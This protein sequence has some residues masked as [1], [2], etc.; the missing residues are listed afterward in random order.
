MTDVSVLKERTPIVI[1]NEILLISAKNEI[2]SLKVVQTP[3]AAA[4]FAQ[5][6]SCSPS[7]LRRYTVVMAKLLWS[8][9][10]LTSLI[11]KIVSFRCEIGLSRL[12]EKPVRGVVWGR[13]TAR[14]IWFSRKLVAMLWPVS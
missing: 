3:I 2:A 9:N 10:W 12:W 14:L 13:V 8:R 6:L 5:L 7:G 4:T 11:V 1:K